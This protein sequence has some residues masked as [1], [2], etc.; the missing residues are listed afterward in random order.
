M[1]T[2]WSVISRSY[3]FQSILTNFMIYTKIIY[4]NMN[5]SN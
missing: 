1:Y 5:D 3:V 4:L 2:L